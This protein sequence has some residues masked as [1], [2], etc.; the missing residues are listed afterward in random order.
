MPADQQVGMLTMGDVSDWNARWFAKRSADQTTEQSLAQMRSSREAI[1]RAVAPLSDADLDRP[2][3][4]SL[5]ST[6]GWRTVGF[7]LWLCLIH[8]WMECMQLRLHAQ[9]DTPIP[10]PAITHTAVDG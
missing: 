4:F 9:R 10:S 1:R 3:W 7:A 6:R 5:V 8:S 2:V